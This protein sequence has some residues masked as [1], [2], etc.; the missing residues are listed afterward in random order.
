MPGHLDGNAPQNEA[1]QNEHKRKVIARKR[2]SYEPWKYTEQRTAKTNQPHFMPRPE[3]PDGGNH[4][5]PFRGR[6]SDVPKEHPR[7]EIAPIQNQVHDEHETNHS[8]PGR[9]HRT[10]SFPVLAPSFL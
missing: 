1:P 3:R 6:F 8:K 2:R 10:L 4:L 5:P 9:N 7:A